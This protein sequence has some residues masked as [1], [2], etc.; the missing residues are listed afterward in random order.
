MQRTLPFLDGMDLGL[1]IND[2]TGEVGSLSAIQFSGSGPA[3]GD[4]GMGAQYDTSLVSTSEQLY[5]ALGIDVEAEGRYGLFSAEGKFSFAEESRFNRSSTFLVARAEI[6]NAFKRVRDPRPQ[7]E[8]D[9]LIADGRMDLFRQRFGDLFIRGVRNGGEYIAVISI[10]SESTSTQRELGLALKASMDGLVA[11]GSASVEI[12]QRAQE[13]RERCETRVST[14]QRG[15]VG[16]QLSFTGTIEQVMTRLRDFA[17]AVQ[18]QPKAYSVQ[19]ASYDT[20]AFSDPPTL[21]D[22]QHQQDVLA[23]CMR[24]RVTLL[25]LRNDV[26]EVLVHPE[27]FESPPETASLSAWSET[28]TQA[29]NALTTHTRRVVASVNDASFFAL[30]LPVD[31]R[32]PERKL[33][34]SDQVVVFNHSEFGEGPTFGVTPRSQTLPLGRYDDASGQLSVGNDAISSI[35][36]PEGLAVRAYEHAWFQGKHIDFTSD[37]SIFESDWNDVISSLIVYRLADGPPK[38]THI[39]ALDFL[40]GRPLIL[41]PGD[42]PDLLGSALGAGATSALLVP[43]GMRVRMFSEP[44]FGGESIDFTSDV[45]QLPPEWDNRAASLQV[46]QDT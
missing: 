5:S 10:T 2:L 11:S 18:Q 25:T 6:F 33:H 34:T 27:F 45:L 21:F 13:L 26:E 31:L 16:Q 42:Y 24:K 43:R 19:A 3:E 32:I 4:P 30:Q 12:S 22:I 35:K 40:W 29:L 8:A 37:V 20:L 15:G 23:D 39:V 17:V 41:D 46:I 14:F 7:E 9:R 44:N 36:V 1:G 28:F 38:I